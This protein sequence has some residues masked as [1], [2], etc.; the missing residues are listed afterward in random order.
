VARRP[1][2][3]DPAA[4]RTRALRLLGWRE[5]SARELRQ[6]L[7]QRGFD[8]ERAAA[9]VDTLA[10]AGWQSDERYVDSLIRS[11]VAQGYGPLRIKSEL[12]AAG[13]AMALIRDNLAA[14]EVD[15]KEVVTTVWTRKFGGPP[16][17]AAD[18]Q[19]QYR[20]LAGRGFEAAQIRAVLKGD[21]DT[22]T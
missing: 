17:G 15:W 19:K 10:K 9:A 20:Y 6:K 8:G 16:S 7:E 4:V 11:R 5:H 3:D 2:S 14:A 13:V 1:P 22:E 12:E 18:W 21:I